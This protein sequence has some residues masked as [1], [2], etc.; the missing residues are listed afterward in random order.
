MKEKY[1]R[2]QMLVHK[3][4]SI[5]DKERIEHTQTQRRVKQEWNEYEDRKFH[6]FNHSVNQ[7][8]SK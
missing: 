6:S 5:L 3:T 2:K 7:R 8:T 1:V 4:C